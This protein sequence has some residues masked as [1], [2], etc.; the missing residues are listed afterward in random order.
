MKAKFISR[1]FFL[2][3]VLM[4]SA[5]P[6]FA[7]ES[8]AV[9]VDEVIAQVNDSVVTLSR[10]RRE[11]K[12]AVE[13]LVQKG[14]TPEAAKTEVEGNK[15]NI[16][17]N[18]IQEELILQKGKEIGVDSDVEVEVNRRLKQMMTEN[19]IK[20]ID[21]LNQEMIKAGVKPDEVRDGWRK[22]F[23]KEIVFQRDIDNRVYLGWGSKEIKDYY[24]KHKEKFTKPESVTLSQIFLNFAGRDQAAVR[25]KADQLI[26]S[27]RGGA[28][29][30]KTATENSDSPDVATNKGVVG[31]FSVKD[32]N[33]KVVA[34]IKDVKTGDVGK[35]ETEEGIEIVRV[36][37]RVA[38]S[39]ESVFSENAVRAAMTYEVLPDERK[40]YMSKL[41]KDSYIKISES[42]RASIE[43]LLKIEEPKTQATKTSK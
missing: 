23:T 5:F 34:V 9:V 4:F 18:L 12:N 26:A 40:K 38:P 42:Y 13:S 28:D 2:F 35:L 33:E 16:I 15:N 20:T 21:A 6:A 7:Q 37:S 19:G 14:K 32:L 8:E 3:A 30:V 1:A 36:D 29:F 25:A 39:N 10:V 41:V 43:P 27:L 11:M 22:Q 17:V 24:E 31:T